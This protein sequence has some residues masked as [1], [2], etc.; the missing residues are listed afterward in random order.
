M[1]ESH[2]HYAK[3]DTQDYILYDPPYMIYMTF[4]N[5]QNNSDKKQISDCQWL[6]AEAGG[7]GRL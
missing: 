2:K 6:E 5:R 3:P 7:G 1:G 4:Y